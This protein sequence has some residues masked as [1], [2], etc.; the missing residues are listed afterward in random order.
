MVPIELASEKCSTHIPS[1][2]RPCFP[3]QEEGCLSRTAGGADA[4]L[5][6]RRPRD[7]ACGL[8]DRICPPTS[9]RHCLVRILGYAE[10]THTAMTEGWRGGGLEDFR[11]T[12]PD[13]ISPE[14]GLCQPIIQIGVPRLRSCNDQLLLR[15]RN[16]TY[17]AATFLLMM[18]N[19]TFKSM[20]S[21]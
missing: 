10:D 13:P 16:C 21:N 20:M 5:G 18:C 4:E 2:L 3:S 15:A 14:R 12:T 9:P 6:Q 8:L 11:T 19:R 1:P 17:I 7:G